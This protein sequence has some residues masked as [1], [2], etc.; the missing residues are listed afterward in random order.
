MVGTIQ[1]TVH[2]D[3]SARIIDK[4]RIINVGTIQY[5]IHIDRSARIIEVGTIQQTVHSSPR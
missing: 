4:P 1:Y 2:K 3:R 5:T